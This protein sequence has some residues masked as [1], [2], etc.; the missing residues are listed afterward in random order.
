MTVD[1]SS[2]P[3]DAPDPDVVVA[4]E[5]SNPPPVMHNTPAG[6]GGAD[7]ETGSSGDSS[8]KGVRSSVVGLGEIQRH[9]P[10]GS[11]TR[12]EEGGVTVKVIVNARGRAEKVEVVES[13]NFPSLDQAAIKSATNARYVGGSGEIVLSFRFNFVK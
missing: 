7:Q 13:S 8:A 12:G 10:L 9:Y 5:R 11:R 3:V 2:S 1:P 4:E 6:H